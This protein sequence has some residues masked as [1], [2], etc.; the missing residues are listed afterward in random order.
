MRQAVRLLAGAAIAIIL[1][2]GLATA[3]ESGS[4]STYA[5]AVDPP[6]DVQGTAR[7]TFAGAVH[8]VS[9]DALD[10]TRFSLTATSITSSIRGEEPACEFEVCKPGDG[11]RSFE[12]KLALTNATI[13]FKDARSGFQFALASVGNAGPM[14]LSTARGSALSTLGYALTE[15]VIQGPAKSTGAAFYESRLPATGFDYRAPAGEL[16]GAGDYTLYLYNTVVTVTGTDA[17]G[18]KFDTSFTLADTRGQ[19]PWNSPEGRVQFFTANVQGGVIDA[20][21][22]TTTLARAGTMTVKASDSVLLRNASGVVN[23]QSVDGWDVTVPGPLD[24]VPLARAAGATQARLSLQLTIADLPALLANQPSPLGEDAPGV[25]A[26]A[27]GGL[28]LAAAIGALAYFWPRLKFFLTALAVPMYTRIEKNDLLAHGTRESIYELIREN[29][30]IHAHEISSRASIGWGTA[31]H[32]LR[33]MENAHLVVSKRSGRYKRFF[34]SAGIAPAQKEAFGVLRNDTTRSIAEFVSENPGCIQKT[35][36]EKFNIQPS[37]V[38]WHM[39]KLEE[40]D[41][42]KKVREGRKVHYFS[43]PA[44]SSIHPD[45]AGAHGT[46]GVEGVKAA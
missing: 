14:S 36:C 6:V 39:K 2:S 26:G 46:A 35:V 42:V 9:A 11:Y 4:P 8:I 20:S 25:A 22:P 18:K 44:W 21:I 30:G 15:S 27:A 38:S 16:S 43:G 28:G 23:G 45:A 12:R 17:S 5:A 31:V 3:S 41:L 7:A 1:A 19:S 40:A 29:P 37:L 10:D 24:I 33:M 13:T 34:M 32:H